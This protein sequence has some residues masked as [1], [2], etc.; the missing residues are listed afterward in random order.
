MGGVDGVWNMIPPG[1]ARSLRPSPSKSPTTS[2]PDDLAA[3]GE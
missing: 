3:N 2:V 1:K